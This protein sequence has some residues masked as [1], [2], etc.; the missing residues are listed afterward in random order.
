MP[1]RMEGRSERFVIG[2][3]FGDATR[4]FPQSSIMAGIFSDHLQSGGMRAIDEK[5]QVTMDVT[6]RDG[7]LLLGDVHLDIVPQ[8]KQWGHS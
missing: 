6:Y 2:R 4:L 7:E 5:P 8:M 3:Y 1:R